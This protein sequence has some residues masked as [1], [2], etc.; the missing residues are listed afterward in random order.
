[1]ATYIPK[2]Y[3]APHRCVRRQQYFVRAGSDFL[4]APHSVLAGMFGCQ[5]QP[6]V[7]H[8]WITEPAKLVSASG[9]EPSVE[10]RFGFSIR[11]RGPGIARDLY[12]SVYLTMPEGPSTVQTSASDLDSWT[13]VGAFDILTT[14]VSKDQV[15]LAPE[16]ICSHSSSS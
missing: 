15:K 3:L 11:S 16:G 10:S 5:P 6:I 7:Y 14:A 12:V 4:P 8:G 13:V 1:V 2:S 9:P